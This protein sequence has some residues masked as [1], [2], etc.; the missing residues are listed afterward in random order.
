M[1]D[2][3][4]SG[5]YVGDCRE[6]LTQLPDGC[7]QTCITSPPYWGLRDYGTAQ[8]EGG[9]HVCDHMESRPS[10]TAASVISSTLG[11]SKATVHA[12]HVF[13]GD[14]G[15]CGARR[16]DRQIGLEAT[17]ELYV[18]AMVDVFRG[19]RRVLRDDGT[20]WLNLGDS[21]ATGAGRVGASPGETIRTRADRDPKHAGKHT[22][23]GPMTQPNRMPIDGLKPKDLVGIPWMTAFALRQPYYTGSIRDER[24]RIWIAAMLDAEGCLFIHKRKAGQNN[25]QGYI[26]QSD[27]YGPGVEICNTSLAVVERIMALVGKGSICSQGPEENQR[28]K[29]RIYRWNLR[30]IECRDFVRELYPYLVAKQHQARILCGCPSSGERAEAAHAALIGLHRGTPTDVDFPPPES[31][32]E[33][34]FYLRSDIIWSKL[35]PM[36]ESVTDRP[37]KAH[38]YLFLLSKSER[39]LYDAD[40]ISEPSTWRGQNRTD[41]GPIDTTMPGA[42]PHRG[43]RA[44]DADPPERRNKRSVW[45]VATQPFGGAHFATF[46]PKLIDPCILAGTRPGDLVLDPFFGSGTTGAVAEKHGRRWIGFDLGYAELAKERTAQRTLPLPGPR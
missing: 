20:L 7:V 18:A 35:N 23:V 14:C 42:P 37:T 30:T 19:V 17:P 12:S 40:A 44:L 27:S 25:G 6:L 21:Y 33:P 45:T 11:G 38:E 9:D 43:L 10:R 41:T 31:M 16:I 22:A 5:H 3:S 29:Q 26:R 32:T 2:V 13:R 15:R 28:R 8:W 46:P 4:T 34:G 24:D 36:P 39:Y 1:I